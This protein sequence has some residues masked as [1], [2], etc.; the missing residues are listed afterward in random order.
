LLTMLPQ[1]TS[2]RSLEVVLSMI[3]VESADYYAHKGL[4][5]G[6]LF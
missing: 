4:V 1:L 2:L 3:P 6:L 5:Q